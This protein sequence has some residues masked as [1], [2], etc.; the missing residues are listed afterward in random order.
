MF[1]SSRSKYN[2][3]PEMKRAEKTLR[4]KYYFNIYIMMYIQLFVLWPVQTSSTVVKTL[5]DLKDWVYFY[6]RNFFMPLN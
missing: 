2:I 1:T 6:Y 5:C 4:I 3:K